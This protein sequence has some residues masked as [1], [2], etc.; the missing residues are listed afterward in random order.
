MIICNRNVVEKIV[1]WCFNKWNKSK[2][3]ENLPKL[4]VYKSRGNTYKIK[5]EY[6]SDKNIIS[7]YLGSIND[8]ED[9]CGIVIHE[10][11]HYLLNP[12]E[13]DAIYFEMLKKG[14]TDITFYDSHPHEILCR[15]KQDK[16]KN[17]CFKKIKEL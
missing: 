5:A 17:E 2:Y 6:N 10:Y 16:Y 12:A 4:R 8:L 11:W 3:V 13:F 15:Q 7:I 1:D 14:F 9:L